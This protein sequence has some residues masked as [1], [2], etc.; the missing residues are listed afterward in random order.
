MRRLLPCV[1]V[2]VATIAWS[3]A[4]HE[5]IVSSPLDS[6]EETLRSTLQSAQPGDVVRF[7]S[8]L[9]PADAL[10]TISLVTPLPS[11]GQGAITI[12][13]SDAGVVLD[14]SALGTNEPALVVTSSNNVLMGLEFAD[15]PAAAIVL[16]D[17]SRNTIG[18]DRAVGAGPSGQG[19]VIRHC[20]TAIVIE[21][22]DTQ[23]NTI[24]GNLIGTGASGR[25]SQGNDIGLVLRGGARGNH[26]GPGNVIA[27][28]TSIDVEIIDSF[29]NTIGP[30]NTIIQNFLPS[31]RIAGDS[32]GNVLTRNTLRTTG[33][34]GGYE[35]VTERAC[36]LLGTCSYPGAIDIEAGAQGG[37]LPPR[38]DAVD[39]RAGTVEGTACPGC[40]VEVFSGGKMTAYVYE[41]AT[42]ADAGGR[43]SF[44]K[45][46]ALVDRSLLL[47]ATDSAL[48]TS[49]VGAPLCRDSVF[50][51]PSVEGEIRVMTWNIF[52]KPLNVYDGDHRMTGSFDWLNLPPDAWEAVSQEWSDFIELLEY[53]NVDVL[54][55]QDADA[56]GAG[57]GLIAEA[58]AARLGYPYHTWPTGLGAGGLG[59][60]GCIFSR[61]EIV[62]S[63]HVDDGIVRAE[64]RLPDGSTLHIFDVHVANCAGDPE[65]GDP[66]E[67]PRMLEWVSPYL[68]LPT[69]VLGDF[70]ANMVDPRIATCFGAMPGMGWSLVSDSWSLRTPAD[71]IWVS[72]TLAPYA[73][74]TR[75][76]TTCFSN[77]GYE[78]SNHAPLMM[79]L[80]VPWGD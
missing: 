57:G 39:T 12:D 46:A 49:A 34:V 59:P 62:E 2:L 45:G 5:W 4:A 28:S 40:A 33:I 63:D 79:I 35:A 24:A 55:V 7:D 16:H 10:A 26:I 64:I 8:I 65:H 11:L 30:D 68:D 75:V 73:R 17:A 3:A 47:T 23:G 42:T 29:D 44:A 56:W 69:I 19:N 80:S 61:Y 71:S 70:N 9:F 21:G 18:G 50:P 74:E 43:F 52:Q 38:I 76:A 14:G 67:F 13:G 15:C 54:A 32:A 1:A 58:V 72:P 66:F 48:G 51:R 36:H 53:A 78:I 20:G 41:G 60:D 77:A 31:I 22:E 6:G 27:Y 25:G 37:I